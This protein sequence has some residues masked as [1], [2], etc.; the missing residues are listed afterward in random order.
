MGSKVI[1]VGKSEFLEKTQ[2]L[3]HMLK[4]SN[5]WDL[6]KRE[7]MEAIGQMVVFRVGIIKGTVSVILSELKQIQSCPIHIGIHTSFV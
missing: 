1:R 6:I 4:I 2:F 7:V 5:V 3:W